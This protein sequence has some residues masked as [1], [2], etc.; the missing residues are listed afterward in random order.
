MVPW[1][2]QGMP[3]EATEPTHDV[4][5]F[6]LF[7]QTV[8][9]M[10]VDTQALLCHNEKSGKDLALSRGGHTLQGG[11]ASPSLLSPT[12]RLVPRPARREVSSRGAAAL[13]RLVERLI[14]GSRLRQGSGSPEQLGAGLVPVSRQLPQLSLRKRAWS[15]G[16]APDAPA[17]QQLAPRGRPQP[18]G[19]RGREHSPTLGRDI[20]QFL[21]PRPKLSFPDQTFLC[22]ALRALRVRVLTLG[23]S[24]EAF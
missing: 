10:E 11:A 15:G 5:H 17:S 9:Q 16:G 19:T 22:G 24:W 12:P 8:V 20:I 3:S 13:G 6:T 4:C 1:Q 21:W 23:S 14:R 7:E 2:G 18:K